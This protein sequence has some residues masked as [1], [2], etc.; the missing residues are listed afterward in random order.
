MRII[1]SIALVFSFF[2][3]QAQEEIA[4]YG[5][6]YLTY[7]SIK[8]N[9]IRDKEKNITYISEVSNPRMLMYK[10]DSVCGTSVI[11]CPGGGY[12]R[13]NIKNAR[14]I[15]KKLNNMGIT[16]FILVYQLPSIENPAIAEQN[17]RAALNLVSNR[18]EEWNLDENKIGILGSSAGGHLAAMISVNSE[19]KTRKPCFSVLSWPVISMRE[20]IVHK[21]SLQKLLGNNRDETMIKHYSAD[22]NVSRDTPPCFIVHGDNDP[23]V[24]MQNSIRF[25]QALRKYRVKSELHIFQQD[26]HGFGLKYGEDDSWMTLLEAWLKKNRFL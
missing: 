23:A 16:V 3:L 9:I 2:L 5:D 26:K 6:N 22:E 21:G 18:S 19:V 17:L 20:D 8:E 10:P 15:A 14:L 11:V 13:L 24:S 7:N 12:Q 4:L 25:Y 1:C